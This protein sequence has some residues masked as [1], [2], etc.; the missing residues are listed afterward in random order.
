MTTIW[1]LIGLIWLH[2]YYLFWLVPSVRGGHVFKWKRSMKQAGNSMDD[3]FYR[4]RSFHS[5]LL[6]IEDLLSGVRENKPANPLIKYLFL[7]L[8]LCMGL[9]SAAFAY[10]LLQNV[11]ASILL[12]VVGWI[13]PFQVTI[14]IQQHR[15]KKKEQ[16]I[17]YFFLM[18]ANLYQYSKDP[19]IA[20]RE[21]VPYVKQ[22][23][24]RYL[25]RVVKPLHYGVPLE[26]VL[27]TA[28]KKLKTP[29]LLDFF[30]DLQVYSRFGG[31]FDELINTYVDQAFQIELQRMERKSETMGTSYVTYFLFTVFVMLMYLMIK[32]QPAAMQL[33][34]T[35]PFGKMTVVIMV[36]ITII[37]FWFTNK[38]TG[39]RGKR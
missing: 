30:T 8:S 39:I 16:Q 26:E 22:P 21:S 13:I 4:H 1:L 32:T 12:M 27:N 28:L 11:F 24:Q 35:H 33:L 25:N 19:L 2:L 37:V 36:L 14:G 10:Y 20:V 29:I 17:P 31:K 38:M 18:V 9:L 23:L 5:Y 6:Q 7:F 34:I 3:W 15:E